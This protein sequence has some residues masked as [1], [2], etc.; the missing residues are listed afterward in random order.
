MHHTTSVAIGARKV[1]RTL[2]PGAGRERALIEA[3]PPDRAGRY[4]ST[5]GTLCG[6]IA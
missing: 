4:Q 3:E 5:N 2:P 6:R 1:L